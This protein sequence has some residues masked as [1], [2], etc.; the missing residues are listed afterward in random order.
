MTGLTYL[1]T[2]LVTYVIARSESLA[3]KQPSKE[4]EKEKIEKKKIFQV[5]FVAALP[6]ISKDYYCFFNSKSFR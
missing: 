2:Y 5:S 1:L 4:K 6:S 3:N